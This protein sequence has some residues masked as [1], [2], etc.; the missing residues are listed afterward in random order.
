V[1]DPEPFF[2]FSPV[3]K[4]LST[5]SCSFFFRF[6]RSDSEALDLDLGPFEGRVLERRE[7]FRNELRDPF[8]FFRVEHF[9]EKGA[10]CVDASR[11]QVLQGGRAG[12]RVEVSAG[13]DRRASQLAFAHQG[14][15]QHDFIGVDLAV[16]DEPAFSMGLGKGLQALIEIGGENFRHHLQIVSGELAGAVFLVLAGFHSDDPLR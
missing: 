14:D 7:G 15:R 9:A 6:F 3:M 4:R 13:V 11:E 8:G 10:D 5:S 12:L 1:P 16:R 2:A